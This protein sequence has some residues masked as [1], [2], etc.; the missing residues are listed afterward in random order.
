MLGSIRVVNNGLTLIPVGT[1]AAYCGPGE[2]QSCYLVQG[3]GSTVCVDL[4]SGALGALQAHVTPHEIDLI[5]V[6]HLHADHL[7]DLLALR[8]YLAFGPGRGHRARVLGPPGLREMLTRFDGDN[9]WEA[10]DFETFDAESGAIQLGNVQMTYREVPHLPPTYAVRFD[11]A[12]A[13]VCLGADCRDNDALPELAQGVDVLVCECSHGAG[14]AP[15]DTIHLDAAQAAAI[16]TRAGASALF[17]T[18][19]PPDHDRA[20]ALAVARRNFSGPVEWAVAA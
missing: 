3:A 17:L 8:I 5:V 16:A 14:P 4:G 11:L 19:C 6:T 1:G 9:H 13:S 7:V 20:E 2:A 12:E 15:K 10:F 18:H